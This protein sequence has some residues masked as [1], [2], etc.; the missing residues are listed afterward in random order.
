MI[1]VAAALAGTARLGL[2]V[3]ANTGM[4]DEPTLSFAEGEARDMARVFQDMGGFQR[5]RL[6]VLQGPSANDV[7]DAMRQVEAQVREARAGGDEAL[8]VFYYSGH[9]GRDGLHLAGSVLPLEDVR[10]WLE[11]SAAQVRVAFVDACESGALVKGGTPTDVVEVTVDDALTASGVAIVTSTGPL[12]AARESSTFGGGV[13]SRALLTGLRG[14]ADA[15][16][17]GVITLDEAYRYAFEATVVGTAQSTTGVQRPEY[18]YAITGVGQ[19]VLTRIPTRAAAVV[20][21]EE[22]EGVYAIVS[23]A[24]GQI[25]ARVDKE[26]GEAKRVSLPTGRY[27]VRKIRQADVL[28]GEVDLVWGGDR[29]VEDGQLDAVPLGDPLARGGWARRD[30]FLAVHGVVAPPFIAGNPFQVG[31]GIAVRRA[32]SPRIHGQV[33]LT[34]STG[35]RREWVGD[36]RTHQGRLDAGV[37]ATRPLR[38][39]D[40]FVSAGLAA[41]LVRQDLRWLAPDGDG[42]VQDAYESH[43]VVLPAAWLG[44]GL[45]VPMGPAVGIDLDVR[46]HLLRTVVDYAPGFAVQGEA[47]LGMSFAL[48]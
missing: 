5:D 12:A 31:G 3:G 17:D 48:R 38:H 9:A 27:V 15:D 1:W 19:V 24:S 45:R 13:F 20:L 47:R 22:A 2:F 6:T 10:R 4:G 39:V 44:G 32:F 34:G 21:P 11:G 26:P 33:G 30:T 16:T 14:S 23:V 43:T 25:V 29:W 36:L 40:P 35:A 46:G 7:R 8:L 28:V 37:V 18:S 42:G 41:F